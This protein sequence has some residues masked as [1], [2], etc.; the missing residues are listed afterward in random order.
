MADANIQAIE[1]SGSH[2]LYLEGLRRRQTMEFITNTNFWEIMK[3]M[4]KYSNSPD[5]S[6]TAH[7]IAESAGLKNEQGN[8]DGRLVAP[9]FDMT[10]S[11]GVAACGSD[12]MIGGNG[13]RTYYVRDWESMGGLTPN[14]NTLMG[15]IGGTIKTLL[16]IPPHG[17]Q[18]IPSTCQNCALRTQCSRLYEN[19]QRKDDISNFEVTRF[20]T[21][22]FDLINTHNTGFIVL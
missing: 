15:R 22:L 6:Q 21:A 12:T 14:K 7:K 20:Y 17:T 11:M 16:S 18:P 13:T 5:T 1:N 2:A 9:Y 10:R 8:P 3:H 4:S 19:L